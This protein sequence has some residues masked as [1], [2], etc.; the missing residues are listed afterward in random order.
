MDVDPIIQSFL[1]EATELLADYESCLL[2]LEHE[3][4]DAETMNRIFR[5][6]HTVKGN[7]S[8]LGFDDI[9]KFTHRLEDLLDQMRKGT[10][11]VTKP[12]IAV[13][14]SA[15]DVVKNLI[16]RIRD[17][18]RPATEDENASFR[19]TFER[20]V[21]LL[22]NREA[23]SET[24][25]PI[26]S[27]SSASRSEAPPTSSSFEV[28][29]P[30]EVDDS[31]SRAAQSAQRTGFE[32]QIRPAADC[33]CRG[34]DPAQTIASLASMGDI[35]STR[36]EFEGVPSLSELKPERCYLTWYFRLLS[37][38]PQ[39]EL[40]AVLKLADPERV[41]I[42]QL[43]RCELGECSAEEVIALAAE[44]A[45]RAAKDDAGKAGLSSGEPNAKIAAGVESHP[46]VAT[47][48]AKSNAG[49]SSSTSASAASPSNI[50]SLRVPVDKVD[51]LINLVGELVITQSMVAQ[52]I[53]NFSMN[54]LAMLA[55]AVGQMDRHAR[56]LRERIMAVR[57]I[58]IK[59]LFSKFQRLVH[60][61][62][63]VTHKKA[64]L[65]IHGEDTE[66]DKTVLEKIGDPLTHLIRNSLD[67]GLETPD[68][69]LAA[70]K[71]EAGVVKL[72]AYQRGGNIFIEV[73]DDG[74]GLNREKILA[75]AIKNGIVAPDH[76]LTDEQI[77]ALIFRPGFS[78][79]EQV[80]AISGR[81]VG[82]DVV[83]KNVESLGGSIS[84]RTELGKGTQFRIALPLTLAILDGQMLRVGEQVYILPLVSITESIQPA[85]GAVHHPAGCGEM[86]IVRERLVPVIRLSRLFGID[87][88]VSDPSKGLLVIMENEDRLAALLVDELLGQQQVVIKSLE[89][90]YVKLRGVSGATI[91][92]DGRVALILDVP[93]L[94]TMSE[95]P[96]LELVTS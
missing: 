84:I 26:V 14:L 93:G 11:E 42:R 90:N 92:G 47:S 21:A 68:E 9:A 59:S 31:S 16:D 54:K 22:E 63:G 82:M 2:T 30:L 1:E 73:S 56:E 53:E 19:A 80:T 51:R 67:H 48:P 87:S 46:A 45:A 74:R 89:E 69:R 85:P 81:G 95:E 24:I 66:L 55:E 25:E 10:R 12:V 38:H 36:C 7:S 83:R 86:L 57:M 29:R 65:E 43:E 52:T 44:K 27:A 32:I 35:V 77:H 61:L 6:V 96:E 50:N 15:G 5:A 13:L 49:A 23:T 3:Q 40:L 4:T 28:S 62:V 8:M 94:I 75:K 60:D 91:L 41:K 18:S 17:D 39:D 70:G 20:I 33:M 64:V 76:Q 79:A 37:T 72:S 78:T 71:P 58:P 34:K 88:A